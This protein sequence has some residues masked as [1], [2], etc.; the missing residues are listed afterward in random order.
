[1]K[2]SNSSLYRHFETLHFWCLDTFE[3]APKNPAIHDDIRLLL[4]NIVQAQS[5][6]ALALET[7]NPR[8]RLD[9][10]DVVVLS[11]TNVKSI[12]KVFTEYSSKKERGKRIISKKGRIRLLDIMTK[13][14]D[15]LGKWRT[16]TASKIEGQSRISPD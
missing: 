16:K 9:F 14:G 15:E 2:A 12:T 13:I 4:E 7:Q 11:I 3:N 8:Q 1:M 10:L 6:I 5:A